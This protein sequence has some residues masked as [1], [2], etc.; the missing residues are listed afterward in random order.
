[1]AT[2]RIIVEV[3]DGASRQG[4]E[5]EIEVADSI[6]WSEWIER[7]IAVAAEEIEFLKLRK[8]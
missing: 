8:G 6:D 7:T 2:I 5:R 1:M 3:L 4:G